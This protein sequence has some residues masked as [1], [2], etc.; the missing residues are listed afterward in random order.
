MNKTLLVAGIIIGLCLMTG[1]L[2]SQYMK[3]TSIER[4]QKKELEQKLF[5]EQLEIAKEETRQD[6]I[7]K[8]LMTTYNNYSMNWDNACDILGKEADCTLPSYK[9]KDLE[10]RRE[11]N[12]SNCYLRFK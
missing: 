3:Q 2:G 9:A 8:C 7:D 1:L 10:S 6:Q 4:Q 11:K 5:E 12:E